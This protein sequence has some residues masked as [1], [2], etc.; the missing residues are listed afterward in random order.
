MFGKKAK[1]I[2][3]LEKEVDILKNENVF[4]EQEIE[5]Y[6]E[7]VK[8]KNAEIDSYKAKEQEKIIKRCEAAKKAA[9]TKKKNKSK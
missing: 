2:Q 9:E 1:R 4:L 7:I 5:E 3:E 6:K 8:N